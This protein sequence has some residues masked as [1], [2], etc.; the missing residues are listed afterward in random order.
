MLGSGNEVRS[1]PVIGEVPYVTERP[2]AE[3]ETGALVTSD[4]LGR[5]AATLVAE[6][7]IEGVHVREMTMAPL[8]V[9]F[10]VGS[11]RAV[12]VTAVRT[13]GGDVAPPTMLTGVFTRLTGDCLGGRRFSDRSRHDLHHWTHRV[14]SQIDEAGQPR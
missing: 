5:L 14:P 7:R 13:G 9:A 2:A 11:P 1:F 4:D 8:A 6:M 12:A 3:H 10:S